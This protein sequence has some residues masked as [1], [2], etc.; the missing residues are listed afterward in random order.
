M[1]GEEILSRQQPSLNL[2]PYSRSPML[3]YVWIAAVVT[4]DGA[5]VSLSEAVGDVF[6]GVR[7]WLLQAHFAWHL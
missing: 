5:A 7:Y 2:I 6:P 4:I 1:Q 3:C